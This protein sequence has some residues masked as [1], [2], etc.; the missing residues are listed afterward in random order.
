[1]LV[2]LIFDVCQQLFF[3]SMH[4][5]VPII[6][7]SIAFQYDSYYFQYVLLYG[8]HTLDLIILL[9]DYEK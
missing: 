8:L 7:I 4:I 6:H 9:H 2:G 1:M 5:L 3:Y